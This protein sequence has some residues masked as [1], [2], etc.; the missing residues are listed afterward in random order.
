VLI[1]FVDTELVALDG[2]LMALNLLLMEVDFIM[3]VLLQLTQLR[4]L[5]KCYENSQLR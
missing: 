2:F 4:L 3:Q 5:L 1:H